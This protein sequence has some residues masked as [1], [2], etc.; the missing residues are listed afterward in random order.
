MRVQILRLPHAAGIPAYAHED[1]AGFDFLAAVTKPT[2]IYPFGRLPIPTGICVAVRPGFEV[3]VRPRSGLALKKGVTVLNAPGTIDAG[4]RGEIQVILYNAGDN[5]FIINRGDRIAQG[6][7]CP[8]YRAEW[9]E[10]TELPETARG[11]AGF[12]SSGVA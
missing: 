2:V 1:D 7:L 10:A 4:Y 3:Q 8:I 11:E 9:E 12:G 5:A 6:V